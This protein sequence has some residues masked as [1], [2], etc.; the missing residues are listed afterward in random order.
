MAAIAA[1]D[2]VAVRSG[3]G[4]GKSAELSWLIYWWLL[5]RFPAK[6]P[7]TA[8]TTH[9]LE[10]VLWGEASKWHRAMKFDLLKNMIEVKADRIVLKAAP[11][12][13]FAVA[14]TAR[15]EQPEAF[16]GFHSENLLFLVDEASGVE[17]IIF[18]VGEGSMSTVGAKSVMMGNPTRTSGYFY[19]A[20]HKDRSKWITQKISCEDS[21][22]VAPAYI[23]DMGAK[24]GKDSNIYR[25]RVLGEF[26]ITDDDSVIPLH[27]CEAAIHR[28]VEPTEY[29]AVWGVDVARF[30]SARTAL[31]KRQ[32]NKLLAKIKSWSGKDTMQ[33]A[34][35]I[36]LEY[37]DTPS[38][39]L[40]VEI[41]IDVIGI[42]AGVV[43]RCSELG[44]P[45][46][47]INVAETFAVKEQYLRMRDELWFKAKEW[48]EARDCSMPDDADLIG[49]L[50]TPKYK[51][52]SA[53]KIQ[54]E[55]KDDMAKRGIRSPDLA[56]AFCLTFA[57]GFHRKEEKPQRYAYKKTITHSAW[58]A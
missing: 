5:T 7:V 54:V 53:G 41:L 35:L 33:V 46:R 55:S 19:N 18:E 10:D 22:L 2:R 12:E 6:V 25:V 56:D 36:K 50:T 44:L 21:K 38:K 52:T 34:G 32:G 17:D 39:E 3:H 42:G 48:L 57:G 9:Q 27:L 40:P 13:S 31:A 30:G 20:F 29:Q 24:Y 8:P 51:I 47:G 26:P 49:E 37:E 4:V 16:Q 1:N 14:R 23:E 58:A 11:N 15:K 28:D 45:V 43:D